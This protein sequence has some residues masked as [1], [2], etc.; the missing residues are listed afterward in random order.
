MWPICIYIYIYIYMNDNNHNGGV[1]VTAGR[2]ELGNPKPE[3]GCLVFHIALLTL[4]K[5]WMYSFSI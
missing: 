4:G 1:R 2:N 5:L 3:Q